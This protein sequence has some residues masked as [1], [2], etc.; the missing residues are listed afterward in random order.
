M[1]LLQRTN[2]YIS[3]TSLV[4][5]I[6]VC[7]ATLQNQGV[8]SD[9]VPAFFLKIAKNIPRIGR[10]SLENTDNAHGIET[11][12]SFDEESWYKDED[13]MSNMYKR[14]INMIKDDLQSWQQFPLSIEGPPELW[15]TLADY[16]QNPV[17]RASTNFNND[18]WTRDKRE[19][20][21]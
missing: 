12:K 6:T 4:L 10:S 1:K 13:K 3:Y 19:E 18:L 8:W 17:H 15:R 9:D 20:F 21:Y 11:I 16:S 2:S 7:Y 14:K 5:F